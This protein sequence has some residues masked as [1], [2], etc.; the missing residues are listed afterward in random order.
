[1]ERHTLL[2]D[3]N[4]Q[5]CIPPKAIHRFNAIPNKLPMAF[6]IE[7]KLINLKFVWNL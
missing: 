5:Y 7:L 2:T 3:G 6:F 4:N 1:M